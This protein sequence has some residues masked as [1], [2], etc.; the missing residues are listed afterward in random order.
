LTDY[1][2]D[3]KLSNAINCMLGLIILPNE[4]LEHSDNAVW[5]VPIMEIEELNYLRIR[6]FEPIHRKRNDEVDY[7]PKT[8]KILL[9]KVRNG[10][11]HQN[12][13]PVNTDGLFTGIKIMNFFNGVKRDLDLEIEFN[14]KELESFALFIAKEYLG[15]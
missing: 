4:M 15:E 12:I 7:Y 3:Y 14:R 9:K 1:T 11:A 13:E 10:L 5:D 2:G 6:K 8:L